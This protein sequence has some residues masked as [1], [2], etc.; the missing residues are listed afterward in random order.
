M[1]LLKVSEV[2]EKYQLTRKVEDLAG[3]RHGTLR[4]ILSGC[5]ARQSRSSTYGLPRAVRLIVQY[6]YEMSAEAAP[7]SP[8]RAAALVSDAEEITKLNAECH[9][10]PGPDRLDGPTDMIRPKRGR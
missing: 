1:L 2:C 7:S 8:R 6:L 5:P 3:L 9:H 4:S 10:I